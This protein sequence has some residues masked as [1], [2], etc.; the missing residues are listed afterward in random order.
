MTLG[1]GI[2]EIA[3]GAFLDNKSLVSVQMPEG[4]ERIGSCAFAETAVMQV[5]LPSSLQ[6]IERGAFAK[7]LK[8]SS[9]E[10]ILVSDCSNRKISNRNR[11]NSN[12]SPS[13][14]PAVVGYLKKPITEV[15]NTPE[16]TNIRLEQVP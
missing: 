12:Y 16:Q 4:L 13:M 15:S 9:T 1:K 8:R 14:L 5:D 6:Q 7:G 3:L 10:Q 11:S 2:R